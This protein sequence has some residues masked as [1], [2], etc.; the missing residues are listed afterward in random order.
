M[1]SIWC[2]RPLNLAISKGHTYQI[3]D[4]FGH[5]T[6]CLGEMFFICGPYFLTNSHRVQTGILKIK[7]CGHIYKVLSQMEEKIH[8]MDGRLMFCN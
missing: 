4:K 8:V 5:K 7:C 6:T 3:K 1:F 2:A